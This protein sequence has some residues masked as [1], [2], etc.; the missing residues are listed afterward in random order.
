MAVISENQGLLSGQT[1]N[2]R[3]HALMAASA[4]V[5]GALLIVLVIANSAASHRSS[6]LIEVSKQ[7]KT[8]DLSVAAQNEKDLV[9]CVAGFGVLGAVLC[10]TKSPTHSLISAEANK[11]V[12]IVH[13]L[14]PVSVPVVAKKAAAATVKADKPAVKAAKSADVAA[15]KPA[16]KAAKSADVAADNVKADKPEAKADEESAQSGNAVMASEEAPVAEPTPIDCACCHSK[17]Q[18]SGLYKDPKMKAISHS[19]WCVKQVCLPPFCKGRVTLAHLRPDSVLFRVLWAPRRTAQLRTTTA[20]AATACVSSSRANPAPDHCFIR[21]R[22]FRLNHP[23]PD[24]HCRLPRLT[25]PPANY[26][27]CGVGSVVCHTYRA[28]RPRPARHAVSLAAHPVRLSPRLRAGPCVGK[29]QI[30]TSLWRTPGDPGLLTQSALSR[31]GS[32]T[33][34]RWGRSPWRRQPPPHKHLPQTSS[35]PLAARPRQVGWHHVA[36][37]VTAC[38]STDQS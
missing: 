25:L 3:R 14:A 27:W 21:K 34:A 17:C 7:L 28:Y 26:L 11:A 9:E 36:V 19:F 33:A 5:S 16:V 22:V 37:T 30:L 24:W 23:V 12:E 15:D 31:G 35:R 18:K 8:G 29:K 38:S 2:R 13:T 10:P 32:A 1:V 20:S 6:A 4:G